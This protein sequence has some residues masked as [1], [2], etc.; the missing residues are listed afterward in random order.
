[1]SN[2]KQL[3]KELAEREAESKIVPEEAEPT[4]RAGVEAIVRNAKQE[5]ERLSLLYMEEVMQHVVVLSVVG[6]HA[7]EFAQLA[8]NK[9]NVATVSARM[10]TEYLIENVKRRSGA[11]VYVQHA[12]FVFLDELNN[13]RRHYQILQLPPLNTPSY[14]DGIYEK[15]LEEAIDKLVWSNYGSMLDSAIVRRE[16]GKMALAARFSGKYLPVVLY[17]RVNTSLDP[18]Y[19]PQP[20]LTMEVTESVN[21][22]MVKKALEELKSKVV[23]LK[24]KTTATEGS[25]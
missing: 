8:Q 23:D 16:I 15:P 20:T 14:Q 19:V 7:R 13:L 10:A 25:K 12:H 2:I 4:I 22:K 17:N 18:R 6:E 1:M 24:A 21:D 5:I 3:L 11:N 9:M